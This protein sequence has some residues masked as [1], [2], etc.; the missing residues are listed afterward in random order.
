MTILLPT[1]ILLAQSESRTF[2]RSKE[3]LSCLTSKLHRI[4]FCNNSIYLSFRYLEKI[5]IE[6]FIFAG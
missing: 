5:G 1:S 6:L 3:N 2:Q 4:I